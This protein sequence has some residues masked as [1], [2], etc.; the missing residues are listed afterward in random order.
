MSYE[1]DSQCESGRYTQRSELC[2]ADVLDVW[3]TSQPVCLGGLPDK[4]LLFPK[5][6]Y[7]GTSTAE[8][9]NSSGVGDSIRPNEKKAT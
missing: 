4:Q 6:K 8:P 2:C 7:S 9:F 5:K 1:L 3:E